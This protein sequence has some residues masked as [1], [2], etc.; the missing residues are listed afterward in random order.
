MNCKLNPIRTAE[1]LG[2]VLFRF[3][4]PA[5]IWAVS[6]I[7]VNLG[8]LCFIQSI[9]AK[10]N[11]IALSAA[12]LVMAT[13]Y[14]RFGFVRLLGIGHLFWVPMLVWFA[15]NLPDRTEQPVLHTWVL[16]L[17]AFNG[18]SLVIDFVDVVRFIRGEREPYYTWH[19]LLPMLEE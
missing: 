14:A 9:Y 15:W 1:L 8:S 13:I 5:R 18:I 10:A 6:L 12:V 16:L 3:Q 7:T 2:I 17:M 4:W 19:S 11:L